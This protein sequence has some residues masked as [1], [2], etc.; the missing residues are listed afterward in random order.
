LNLSL[1][2]EIASHERLVEGAGPQPA[3]KAHNPYL[4]QMAVHKA[5]IQSIL[6]SV[7][8]S[9]NATVQPDSR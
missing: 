1:K 7:I 5:P 8:E 3:S 6:P 4:E 9:P 2:S